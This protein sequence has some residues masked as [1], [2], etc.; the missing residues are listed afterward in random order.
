MK[1]SGGKLPI[2]FEFQG[3]KGSI[4]SPGQPGP[5]SEI[6]GPP[7]PPVGGSGYFHT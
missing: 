4:G 7:G 1:P 6:A 5:V 3:E 2:D